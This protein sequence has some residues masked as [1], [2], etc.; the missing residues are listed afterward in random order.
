MPKNLIPF[1][2]IGIIIAAGV[3]GVY[4][5]LNQS[6]PAAEIKKNAEE[7]P[8]KFIQEET[9]KQN[10]NT[11]NPAANPT[12][13]VKELIVEDKVV[14]QGAEVKSGDTILMHYTGTLENGQKFDSS[15]DRGQPF[16]TQIGVGQVIKGWDQGVIGMKVGGKRKLTI[17]SNLAYGEQGIPGAI[18]GNATL[19]FELELLEIK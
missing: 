13:S 16:E 8:M 2:I 3:L 17:P 11:Q 7:E 4:F 5:I 1:I 12:S 14:G 6:I 18:P 9:T 19:I 10:T 15:V